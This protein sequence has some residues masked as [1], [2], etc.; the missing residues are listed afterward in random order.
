VKYSDVESDVHSDSC[1]DEVEVVNSSANALGGKQTP[2]SYSA[3]ETESHPPHISYNIFL[4]FC[5]HAFDR[6]TEGQTGIPCSAVQMI[7]Y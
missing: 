2:V 3:T 4:P 1:D 7:K 6:R 5:M